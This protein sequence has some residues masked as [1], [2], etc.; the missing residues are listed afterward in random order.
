MEIVELKH[1]TNLMQGSCIP[2]VG[3]QN[4]PGYDGGL[5]N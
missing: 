4:P 2:G 5:A 1:Q 3:C